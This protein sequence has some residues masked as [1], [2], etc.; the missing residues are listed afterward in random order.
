MVSHPTWKEDNN[1]CRSSV[2]HTWKGMFQRQGWWGERREG[3]EGKLV[4]TLHLYSFDLK[5]K[6]AQQH[7]RMG[8][9]IQ[10]YTLFQ[11]ACSMWKPDTDM[12]SR[13]IPIYLSTHLANINKQLSLLHWNRQKEAN[14]KKRNSRTGSLKRTIL[15]LEEGNW[16]QWGINDACLLMLQFLINKAGISSILYLKKTSHFCS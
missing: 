11:L 6:N 14:P 13:Y 16:M 1:C 9:Y 10:I 15:T 7:M 5:G 8:A 12:D 4:S 2:A 3:K